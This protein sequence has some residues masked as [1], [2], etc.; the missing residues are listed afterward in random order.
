MVDYLAKT[1]EKV[2][3]VVKSA[4]KSGMADP[5]RVKEVSVWLGKTTFET[6]VLTLI[7]LYRHSHPRSSLSAKQSRITRHQ[8][9]RGRESGCSVC[10]IHQ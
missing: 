2:D 1:G 7:Q 4:V 3:G 6:G 10:C 5:D 9:A 8:A